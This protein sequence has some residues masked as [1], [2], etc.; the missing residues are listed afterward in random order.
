MKRWRERVVPAGESNRR[1][2]LKLRKLLI[3]QTARNAKTAKNVFRGYAAATRNAAR[4]FHAGRNRGYAKIH[5]GY[6]DQLI[7]L[8][9]PLFPIRIRLCNP[10]VDIDFLKG[11]KFQFSH[12]F[13]WFLNFAVR[14]D[15]R[16]FDHWRPSP[17]DVKDC[18]TRAGNEPALRL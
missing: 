16:L 18:G 15:K 3:L 17:G 2:T 5:F 7:Y 10:L 9:G 14:I 1:A 11:S 8:P 6:A 4:D 13:R 12:G